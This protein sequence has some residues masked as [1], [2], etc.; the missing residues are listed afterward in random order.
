MNQLTD[1]VRSGIAQRNWYASLA[2]AL[3]LPDICGFLESPNDGSPRRYVA[4]CDCYLA[5]CYT[6]EAGALQAK[7][8]FLSGED[9]YALR[10]AFL[11]EGTDDVTRQ[12]ARR[13]LDSFLF[14][15]PP[16]SGMIHCNQSNAKLQLQ[17]DIFCHDLC[18]GVDQWSQQVLSARPDVQA[19]TKELLSIHSLERGFV[20]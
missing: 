11:H 20:F 16:A 7:Y 2:L 19:R 17:V 14:V 4:W 1:A 3:A 12:R 9:C 13:A 5:P 6:R 10:C 18:E 8:V 15:E